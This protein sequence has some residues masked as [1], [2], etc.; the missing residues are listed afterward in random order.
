MKINLVSDLHLNFSDMTLPG[1]DILIMAGDVFDAFIFDAKELET[2]PD[3]WKTVQKQK[4]LSRYTRFLDEEMCKYNTVLY[5]M[6]NHEHYNGIFNDT[7]EILKKHMPP[8]VRLLEKDSITI[9]NIDFFGATFW[10]NIINTKYYV[11]ARNIERNMNDYRVVRTRQP[12]RYGSSLGK[13]QVDHTTK[14]HLDTIK[15]LKSFLN[16]T[17]RCV[18]ISHHAPSFNSVPLQFKGEELNV[19][20]ATEL[21]ELILDNPQIKTW[22]HGHMHEPIDYMIGGTR[23]LANPRGYHQAGYRENYAFDPNFSFEV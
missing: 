3:N 11:N 19:A 16:N 15:A 5:V 9:N 18:I 14:V 7:E 6:G 20:F 4:Y 8:N 1:G 13:L 2:H 10:T 22:V 12:T 23:V 17:K 21:S